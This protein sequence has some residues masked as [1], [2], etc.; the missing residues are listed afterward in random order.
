[1]FPLLFV[2][3]AFGGHETIA[4]REPQ[5][6]PVGFG[7][8]EIIRSCDQHLGQALEVGQ[9]NSVAVE[10][11]F[12]S[13]DSIVGDLLDESAVVFAARRGELGSDVTE[14][15]VCALF[16]GRNKLIVL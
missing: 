7:F 13:D 5:R 11:A 16:D 1:M 10:H 15:G 14:D 12:E 6:F 3:C 9:E 4:D 8:G 2:L